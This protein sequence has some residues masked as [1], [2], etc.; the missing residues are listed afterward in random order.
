MELSD[1][2]PGPQV[3]P[4]RSEYLTIHDESGEMPLTGS[5]AVAE[6]HNGVY[7]VN[8][9]AGGFSGASLPEPPQYAYHSPV[10]EDEQDFQDL[11]MEIG[12]PRRKDVQVSACVKNDRSNLIVAT[13]PTI[14]ISRE[15]SHENAL[16]G[17]DS[18]TAEN[19]VSEH[20]IT[21]SIERSCAES[22]DQLHYEQA[23]RCFGCGRVAENGDILEVLNGIY[24]RSCF[25]CQL[26]RRLLT[27]SNYTVEDGK[28]Q[29]D[30][31][32][33]RSSGEL[34]STKM[35]GFHEIPSSHPDHTIFTPTAAAAMEPQSA[36]LEVGGSTADPFGS[37]PSHCYI[38]RDYC[39]ICGRAIEEDQSVH[40]LDGVFHRKCFRCH[41][42]QRFLTVDSCTVVNRKLHCDPFC[43]TE[44][45]SP[46]S[47]VYNVPKKM[48]HRSARELNRSALGNYRT[49]KTVPL[50][51][52]RFRAAED[53]RWRS[54]QPSEETRA[55][56]LRSP[57]FNENVCG[58]C[59]TTTFN[60]DNVVVNMVAYHRP[61]FR[62]RFCNR[63]LEPERYN[64]IDGEPC[65]QPNCE[66]YRPNYL[67]RS[68]VR[69]AFHFQ[70]SVPRPNHIS[71][72]KANP[73][74]SVKAAVQEP[75]E[76]SVIQNNLFLYKGSQTTPTEEQKSLRESLGSAAEKYC[77]SCGKLVY[78]AE[79]LHVMERYYHPSCFRCVMCNR[80][81]DIVRYHSHEGRPYCL[82][83]HR[84]VRYNRSSSTGSL[85]H[86][87]SELDKSN[88][89]ENPL[90]VAETPPIT[91]HV[92]VRTRM[93][94]SP[95]P[96]LATY[97]EYAKRHVGEQPMHV[98]M[99]CTRPTESIR[100][101]K[102][103]P[104]S[105][106]LLRSPR[107]V[108]VEPRDLPI[109]V[110]RDW[111][112]YP[113][114]ETIVTWRRSNESFRQRE[115]D[116]QFCHSCNR[117]VDPKNKMVMAEHVY[118]PECARCR[119][120]EIEIG[121]TAG[122]V[123]GGVL[124]C[125]PHYSQAVAD[126]LE[127]RRRNTQTSSARMTPTDDTSTFNRSS[128]RISGRRP[129]KNAWSVYD[130]DLQQQHNSYNG[131]PQ[132]ISQ[133]RINLTSAAPPLPTEQET[134]YVP[135]EKERKV[136]NHQVQ[137]H[138]N[139][140]NPSQSLG[141]CAVCGKSVFPTNNVP[142]TGR[143]YHFYCLQCHTCGRNLSPW[144]YRELHG[145]P[146]CSKDYANAI[147]DQYATKMAE[148]TRAINWSDTDFVE[149]KLPLDKTRCYV[150][151]QKSFATETLYVMDRV[152]H[153][154]CF[155]CTACNGTLGVENYHSIDGQPY[156][157]A[158]FRAILSARGI[159][160][161]RDRLHDLATE[162]T[163]IQDHGSIICQK[164]HCPVRPRD[165]INVLQQYYHYNC[166]KC[167]KCGQVLN[168][169]KFE[170]MQGKPYCPADFLALFGRSV[171]RSS[172]QSL[173]NVSEMVR[174]RSIERQRSLERQRSYGRQQS[175]ERER[176]LERQRSH[177]SHAYLVA[178][179]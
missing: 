170:M 143:L 79:Q 152:Y 106:R 47:L 26:C 119:T 145:R 177:H 138:A 6:D 103:Q 144:S 31:P 115:S 178:A 154:R 174:E 72:V 141:F 24:H 112:P 111:H 64:I 85:R 114:S 81:L 139:L 35:N 129:S 171:G 166:F 23:Q 162:I 10:L 147:N 34:G 142:L 149:V 55:L 164:C 158:H 93:T 109:G 110:T 167:E 122:K 121:K 102:S 25:R 48:E 60:T 88:I 12:K 136:D 87:D 14:S 5:V 17:E 15:H 124:Y 42:C 173:T 52:H 78:A 108:T 151:G 59:G 98:E 4:T 68:Y 32:C 169:G 43:E 33:E 50:S 36:R 39:Y 135:I 20:H 130:M 62:C 165:C 156:C 51:R 37:Q 63:M 53:E 2:I 56:P 160:K 117:M 28:P 126:Y 67:A 84:H 128:F 148:E 146:Y 75:C 113:T 127:F 16:L 73:T 140:N 125:M 9:Q 45:Q 80:V 76:P 58:A 21:V 44:T 100:Q 179:S 118:H 46:T 1:I 57:L 163:D 104:A 92:I 74:K 18:D 70:T 19:S 133:D 49:E 3:A 61:C 116:S 161:I 90:S 105:P 29:C 66:K 65:C 7:L 8:R 89:P 159:E 91:D 172:R 27:L 95:P 150:C 99:S 157:K 153:K 132:A 83:H 97:K 86:S 134:T 101:V 155:K 82:P 123:F 41:N 71:F 176:S 94:R 40:A 30:F 137:V 175:L 96:P 107:S 168:I 131:S 69:P 22:A 120:C 13:N 11:M 38:P 54:E 77:Y